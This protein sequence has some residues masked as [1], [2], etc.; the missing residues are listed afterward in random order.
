MIECG[1]CNFG[2]LLKNRK[3]AGD[4]VELMKP[5]RDIA[6]FVQHLHDNNIVHCDIKPQ[7]VVRM[8]SGDIKGIDLDGAVCEGDDTTEQCVRVMFGCKVS[9]AFV[10][11]EC[12]A[13]E[14]KKFWIPRDNDPKC[15]KAH[16]TMDI[17]QYG[18]LLYRAMH[19]T[20]HDLFN[21]NGHDNLKEEQR[22]LNKIA[23]WTEN[24]K[25]QK[26]REVKNGE[27]QALLRK[28]LCKDPKDRLQTVTEVLEHGTFEGKF[29]SAHTS[30]GALMEGRGSDPATTELVLNRNISLS[31]SLSLSLS[32]LS[33]SS[34]PSRRHTNFGVF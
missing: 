20:G 5:L 15:K 33:F 17:W 1:E 8:A 29:A 34:P 26:L 18:V 4:R 30:A 28:I 16:R 23:E 22:D 10:P 2:E 14:G 27:A 7:N 32:S 21:A 19:P 31:P 13:S 25:N 12:I 6:M 3:L 11:P 9:S 24:V